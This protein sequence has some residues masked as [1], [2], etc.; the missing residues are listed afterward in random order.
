M[1]LR[2]SIQKTK[3]FFHKALQNFRSLFFG[4]Y[5]KLPK[6]FSCATTSI[7]NH[8]NDQCYADSCNEWC[9][10]LEKAT[11]RK[12]N[13]MS[14]SKELAREEDGCN[15]S[16]LKLPS[17]PLKKKED[18][19]K[20]EKSKKHSNS[21]REEKCMDKDEGGYVLAKKM[22]ELEMMDRSD[23]E[24]MLDVEE[25]LHYY[26]RL[27][28]PVYVGIVDKFFTDMYK[29]FSVPQRSASINSSRGRLGSIRL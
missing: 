27:R 23:M 24:H 25:A 2:E 26:S 6:P 9:C 4:G 8:Q 29:E 19:I 15:E 3:K 16:S 18:G 13:G 10:D 17:S 7:M 28:S 14:L 11:K 21:R 12:K 20:E 1:Q 22:K 5:Q